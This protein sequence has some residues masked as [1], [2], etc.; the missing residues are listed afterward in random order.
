MKKLHIIIMVM[1]ALGICMSA[2][3]ADV[4]G[5][6]RFQGFVTDQEG[7]PLEGDFSVTFR[8]Y[9]AAT[10]GNV[11]WEQSL[12]ASISNGMI[13]E[14]LGGENPLDANLFDGSAPM[15]LGITIGDDPEMSPR[16]SISSIPYAAR[17]S[18]AQH[19]ENVPTTEELLDAASADGRFAEKAELID[20]NPNTTPV[21]W[22]DLINI[23]QGFADN[24]DDVRSDEDIQLLIS[25]ADF[26]PA[27]HDHNDLYSP[28][29]HNHDGT[30][31][32]EAHTHMWSDISDVPPACQDGEIL[33][34]DNIAAMWVCAP[35]DDSE[36]LYTAA[37]GMGLE[38]TE[39]SFG[40]YSTCENNQTLLWN[41]DTSQWL[42]GYVARSEQGCDPGFYV[43]GFDA[44]GLMLCSA[45]AD[46]ASELVMELMDSDPATTPVTW[47]DLSGIPSGFADGVDDTRSDAEIQ[48]LIDAADYAPTNHEH[49]ADYVNEGQPDSIAS[50]M[51]VD[52]SVTAA[53]LADSYSLSGHGH[54]AD[55]VNEG[56]PD[57][58]TSSM[59][60]DG[61]I[62]AADLA[63]SYSLSTHGHDADYVNEG[64]ADSVTSPMILDGTVSAADLEESYSL[65]THLHDDRYYTE[66]ES[67]NAF[68]DVAGDTMTGNLEVNGQI[69]RNGLPA[70]PKIIA[71]TNMSFSQD[72]RSGWTRY[73]SMGDDQCTGDIPLGFTYTG[74]GADTDVIRVSSNGVLFFGAGCSTSLSNTALPTSRTNL[75][76]LFFFWDDLRDYGT[77]EYFDYTTQGIAGG[78]VFMLWFTSRLWS[79]VCGTNHVNAMIQIHENSNLVEVVYQGITPCDQIKGSSATFGLQTSGGLSATATMIGYNVPLLD[80]NASRQ[81]MSFMPPK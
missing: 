78:R 61:T 68:V 18:I 29:D 72:D 79:D 26:A 13:S 21:T 57:S 27:E 63:D 31:A 4:P 53:D 19:A 46:S 50:S 1:F 77:G 11:I 42:C 6:M 56:Q 7:E 10:E 75:P 44:S 64:Q 14:L 16:Q 3:M 54:D 48:A 30:Y 9:D 51:I 23:P 8:I 76:M 69:T 62:S 49:D 74:F 34:W 32:A 70:A 81:F 45:D 38:L 2:A 36:T 37:E 58:V 39:G 17:A 47:A 15:W 20:Q 52:G 67:D 25:Q 35:D 59:I 41:A 12:T 71:A 65:S 43:A 22:Q 80:D 66:T 28:I 73:E 24:T 60:V 55:Y 5:Q 40:L 33:K